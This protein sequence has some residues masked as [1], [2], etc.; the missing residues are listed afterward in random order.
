MTALRQVTGHGHR[1][2]GHVVFEHNCEQLLLD[3][4]MVGYGDVHRDEYA[5]TSCHNTLT[6]GQRSQSG[7]RDRYDTS[8]TRFLSTSGDSCPGRAG[9]IDWVTVDLTAVYPQAVRAVRHIVFMRPATVVL[10]DEVEA[11]APEVVEQNFTCLGPLSMESA[12]LFVSTAKRNRLQIH[13]QATSALG[14]A[15]RDWG[16]HWR[17]IPSYRL[18]RF[19]AD[20]V[21]R[22]TFVTALTPS[23][24]AASPPEIEAVELADAI[25]VR[26]RAAAGEDLFVCRLGR[27]RRPSAGYSS[28]A[29][30]VAVRRLDGRPVGAAVLDGTH[31]ELLGH[32]EL[33]RR[34]RRGLSGVVRTDAGWEA[35]H[36]R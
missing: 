5:H 33:I 12:A 17:H 1:D 32:G 14:H 23:P 11:A 16:T 30:M 22:C 35:F 3:P 4:G 15:L 26:I 34:D 2:R 21:S 24:L 10:C 20:P 18:R 7:G 6:F 31:L 25:A 27:A 8:I 9:G 19:T 13:T 29:R 28:D 36:D